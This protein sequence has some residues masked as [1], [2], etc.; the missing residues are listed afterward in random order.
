MLRDFIHLSEHR[1]C[2][3]FDLDSAVVTV[4]GHRGHAAEVNATLVDK[5]RLPL[6]DTQPAPQP[7]GINQSFSSDSHLLPT[8]QA[9]Y[10]IFNS[11]P[12][13]ISKGLRGGRCKTPIAFNPHSPNTFTKS[14]IRR[15]FSTAN[16]GSHR[17]WPSA[18]PGSNRC[19]R[20]QWSTAHGHRPGS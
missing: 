11:L 7:G 13:H 5:G 4:F 20:P 10:S 3:I 15:G 17:R 16:S 9:P 6:L 1:S 2:L 12:D 8:G 19:S 18:P 14:P